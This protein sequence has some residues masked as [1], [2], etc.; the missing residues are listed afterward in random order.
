MKSIKTNTKKRPSMAQK[1]VSSM[2]II[3]INNRCCFLDCNN[4]FQTTLSKSLGSKSVEELVN[5][6]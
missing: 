1:H 5:S 3:L 4:S 2:W 6:W